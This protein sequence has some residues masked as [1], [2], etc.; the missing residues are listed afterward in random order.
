M[1]YF[2]LFIYLY[3]L[4][5]LQSWGQVASRLDIKNMKHMTQSS[6]K[7]FALVLRVISEFSEVVECN[8]L[9]TNL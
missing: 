5:K 9:K 2:Y 7:L 4:V 8:V 6:T 3:N 1:G